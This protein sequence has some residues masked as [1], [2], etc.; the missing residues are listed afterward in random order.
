MVIVIVIVVAVA[1]IAVITAGN[2]IASGQS[3]PSVTPG[4]NDS[5]LDCNNLCLQFNNRRSERCMAQ[6]DVRNAQMRL[7]ILSAQRDMALRAWAVATAAAM[8]A[9]FIPVLGP[10]ISSGFATAA[11]IAFIAFLGFVGAVNGASADLLQKTAIVSTCMN[12]EAEARQLLLTKCPE[13]ASACLATPSP[14]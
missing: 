1:I 5:G 11:A 2:V 7:D 10:L 6:A 8:A 14:C 3:P 12:K 13:Q 4:N 9:M